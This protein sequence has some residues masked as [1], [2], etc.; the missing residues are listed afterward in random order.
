MN[1]IRAISNA[2]NIRFMTY[3]GTMNADLFLVFLQRLVQ[4]IPG[5][6]T[7]IV[8][9][10]KAHDAQKVRQWVGQ[11][12]D[13]IKRVL[14]PRRAAELN[15]DEYLN[16]DLKEHIYADGLPNSQQEL[17]QRIQS[18]LHRLVHWPTRIMS[19]F[20]HPSALYASG[21]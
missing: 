16:N 10:L 4:S 3:S 19:Y 13:Q 17:R 5:K 2:G 7:L 15:A 18:F 20:L 6:I 1:V 9:R 11:H 8:D 14:S 12:A 21:C